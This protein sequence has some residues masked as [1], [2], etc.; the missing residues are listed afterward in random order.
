MDNTTQT[1][2]DLKTE[3]YTFTAKAGIDNSRFSLKYQK[4]LNVETNE[5][6][7]NNVTVYKNKGILFVNSTSITINNIK[8][9]TME[10]KLIAEQ[11]NVNANTSAIKD[12]KAVHQILIVKIVGENN[13][14][15]T[16]KVV[17]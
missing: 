16:K 8:V 6:N 10:G 4:T 13:N 11:K 15:V 9:Y 17:N 12:L 5:F 7:D 1:Q 14:C 3:A 2:T